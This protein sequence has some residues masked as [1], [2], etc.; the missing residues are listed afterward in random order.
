MIPLAYALTYEFSFK[1]GSTGS[2]EGQFSEPNGIAVNSAN[3]FVVDDQQ[4]RIEIFDLSGNFVSTFGK[5]VQTGGAGGVFEICTS[6]C[7]RGNSGSLNGEFNSPDD[8]AVN[9]THIIVSDGNNNRRIQIFDLS[10]NFVSMFG[11]GVLDGSN[12]FQNCTAAVTCQTGQTGSGDG[13]FADTSGIAVNSTHILVADPNNRRIQI[14]DL[15]GNFVSMFGKDVSSGAG[16]G[17]VFEICTSSCQIGQTGGGDGEF[18]RPSGIAVTSTHIIV[19]DEN[20]DRIQIHDLN[21][22]F[23]STFGFGVDAGNTNSFQICTSSCTAGINGAGDGQLNGPQDVDIDSDGNIIV[24]DFSNRRIVTYDSSGNFVSMFGFNV[25][26]GGVFENCVSGCQAG[27]TGTA[28]GQFNDPRGIAGGSNNQIFVVEESGNRVQVFSV[29]SSPTPATNGG[30]GSSKDYMTKPTFGLDHR[31]F[32][33]WVT[34]GFSFNGVSHDITDNYWTPFNEKQVRVG[35]INNFTAKVYADKGLRT[36]E[37]LF[38]IPEVGKA[39]DAEVVVEVWYDHQKNIIDFKLSQKTN[40][41]DADSLT[42]THSMT[43]CS[44]ANNLQCDLTEISMK[45]L[46]PLNDKVMAINAVDHKNRGQLT[47]QN[48]GFDISGVSLNPM[49]TLMIPSPEKYE[50]LIEVM[51]I[52]K[53]SDIWIANDGREFVM[54]KSGGFTQINESFARHTDTGIMKNRL[55]SGFADYKETQATNAIEQ[56]LEYC[57]TC[58][59]SFADFKDSFAYEYP[60]TVDRLEILSYLMII[61]E[62]KAIKVLDDAQLSIAHPKAEIDRDDRPISIILAEERLMKKIL[63]DERAYLKQVLA[64]QR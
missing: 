54:D 33:P 11:F 63:A 58:L 3:I 18:N 19:S 26:G 28:D 53:Y 59:T 62:R 4:D 34:G 47:Y 55:H 37:F 13:Q 12:A 24:A 39:Q 5:N 14:F 25:G 36:Q 61:E 56:L 51:Q 50:G 27:T 6:S 20:N 23:V 60:E 15:S 38:G 46:E 17:G 30:G 32:Q 41:V 16:A 7:S 29:P 22:N 35:T 9:S 21:G 10:G 52:A 44:S 49:L 45:F 1:F 2:A 57:P 42:V 64:S 31:S 43:D 48:E 8:I 40:V